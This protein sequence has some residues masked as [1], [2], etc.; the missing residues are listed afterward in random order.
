MSDTY[1]PSDFDVRNF[2]LQ[3][4]VDITKGH[5]DPGVTLDAAEKFYAFLLAA[6]QK[7][8]L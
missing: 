3:A 4:A 5:S 2:A 1:T 8:A 6:D 7:A